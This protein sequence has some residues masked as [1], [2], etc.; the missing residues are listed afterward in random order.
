MIKIKIDS[1]LY[2]FL[3]LC[4]LFSCSKK[5]NQTK[6]NANLNKETKIVLSS[7]KSITAHTCIYMAG[8]SKVI[9]PL[10]EFKEIQKDILKNETINIL[11]Q[12]CLRL[13]SELELEKFIE[14]YTRE[15]LIIYLVGNGSLKQKP[16][17]TL[18]SPRLIIDPSQKTDSASIDSNL[19]NF[20]IDTKNIL[21]LLV[22]KSLKGTKITYL[23]DAAMQGPLQF[24][25]ADEKQYFRELNI[26]KDDFDKV[27]NNFI[28]IT[29][30]DFHSP[31]S[32]N[33]LY[34]KLKSTESTSKI[35]AQ[36]Q[37]PKYLHGISSRNYDSL[38]YPSELNLRLSDIKSKLMSD[39]KFQY[40]IKFLEKFHQR[41]LTSFKEKKIPGLQLIENSFNFYQ[42]EY[43][44]LIFE[45]M[46]YL[47][48]KEADL[49]K[50]IKEDYRCDQYTS[51]KECL[52]Q[53]VENVKNFSSRRFS[54]RISTILAYAKSNRVNLYEQFLNSFEILEKNNSI[55]EA[56]SGDQF[57]SN[58][59]EDYAREIYLGLFSSKTIEFSLYKYYSSFL[60]KDL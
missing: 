6:K 56:F 31:N 17:S 12:P 22:K 30:G 38:F 44:L 9:D 19:I 50:T 52:I 42:L 16:D 3:I 13:F 11:G 45:L 8:V 43:A 7:S 41:A 40:W 59:R 54:E 55:I 47:G 2:F 10:G 29:R 34:T 48:G 60:M 14:D 5:N 33:L 46:P 58:L 51:F 1:L 23:L 26:S 18:V 20:E 36:I 53:E 49:L 15:N 37:E 27:Q 25:L 21:S 24:Y 32:A 35:F 4:F 39:D 28:L 57:K